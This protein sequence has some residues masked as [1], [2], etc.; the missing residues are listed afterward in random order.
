LKQS[1]LKFKLPQKYIPERRNFIQDNDD[2]KSNYS[3]IKND[4]LNNFD[5]LSIASLSGGYRN[6]EFGFN[7]IPDFKPFQKTSFGIKKKI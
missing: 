2:T 6:S 1:S 7:N 4:N 3:Y 5:T